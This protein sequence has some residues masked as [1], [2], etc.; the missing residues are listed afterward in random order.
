M[1]VAVRPPQL[2]P[3]AIRGY[4]GRRAVSRRVRLG[5]QPESDSLGRISRD[6]PTRSGPDPGPAG[7]VTRSPPA[8]AGPTGGPGVLGP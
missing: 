1:A 5:L 7:P 4:P 8:L 2:G 3:V 6:W